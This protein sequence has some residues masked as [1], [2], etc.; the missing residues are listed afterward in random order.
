MLEKARQLVKDAYGN[1][2]TKL[3]ET[4]M[5][6]HKDAKACYE[7]KMPEINHTQPL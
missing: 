7:L 6:S 5:D 1:T 2:V 4:S 3:W